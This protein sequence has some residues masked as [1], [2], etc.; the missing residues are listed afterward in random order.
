MKHTSQFPDFAAHLRQLIRVFAGGKRSGHPSPCSAERAEGGGQPDLAHAPFSDAEFN[1]L[2]LGLFALQVAQNAPYRRICQARGA[3]PENVAAWTQI[4]A[5]P[6]AAF[7][8]LEL[9]CLPPEQRTA[10]FHS[11][12]TAGLPPSRHYHN[13]QS[14]ALYQASLLPWFEANVLDR[15]LATGY[16]QLAIL[17]PPPPQAPHSSLVHMFET[18]RRK[19][20]SPASAFLGQ[21]A[22]DGA[23]T[24][25][26]EAAT[27]ALR[28]SVET[29]TPLLLLGTAFLFVR[30]L[31]YLARRGLQ[32]QLPPGSR[33][34]ETGG[35]KGRSRALPKSQLHALITRRLGISPASIIGEYG[36]TELSS[37]AYD[38][39]KGC[40]PAAQEPAGSGAG[41]SPAARGSG[42]R[43]Q[44]GPGTRPA[45]VAARF[46]A[47]TRLPARELQTLPE[48][49]GAPR[50]FRFPPWARLQI[51]SPET[52]REAPEGETGLIRV[53][54]LANV[55][56]VLAIQTEDLGRRRGD[57]FECLGRAALAEPRG[58]SLMAQW[59]R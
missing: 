2:A 16:W 42:P 25:D 46:M 6:T 20:G 33:A 44:C 59:P 27:A 56:S 48:P 29:G 50:L 58:C 8:E 3:R 5:V 18:L 22:E 30:L 14:L 51:I 53:F 12:G 1:R 57:G 28:D 11:S 54:D 45:A 32:F 52:G 10:V 21:A 38:R 9:S 39:P 35:Y 43:N 4:P 49:P 36:M 26:P 37:Q 17:T 19:S 23:W 34:M 40:P 55:Y 15:P 41:L 13:A 7:K 47:P 31:D 24:L